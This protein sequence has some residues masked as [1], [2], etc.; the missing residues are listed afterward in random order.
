LTPGATFNGWNNISINGGSNNFQIMLEGQELTSAYQNQ[1]SDELQPSVEAIEQFTIQT[2]NFS[3]EY[4]L[5]GTGGLYNFTTKSG[6]NQPHGSAYEYFENTF[7]NAGIPFTGGDFSG[8]APQTKVVKHTDDYGGTFG[9]PVWIPKI[10]NGKNKTFFFFNLERYRDRELLFAGITTVPN[11]SFRAGDFSN[12]LLVTTPP[13]RVLGT[14]FA[15]QTLI[16]NTIYD[17]ATTTL[18]SAGQRILSP[19]P[20]NMIPAAR[21]NPVSVALLATLPQPN[22]GSANQFVNNYSQSGAFFKLQTLPSL[23]LD[24]NIGTKVKMSLYLAMENTNKS[25]GVDGLPP[26]ISQVRDQ[27]IRSKTARF[28]FDETLSPTLLFHFGA[29]FYRHY[30]PDQVTGAS[31]GYDL[32]AIGQPT[33]YLGYPR[34]SGIGDSTYGGMAPAFGPGTH[35]H[36]I[37]SKPTF[38]GSLSKVRGNHTIKG[39]IEWK[40]DQE[41]YDNFIYTS[42]AFAFSSSETSQPLYGQVLPSGTGLGSGFASFLLGLYDSGN[43]GNPSQPMYRRRSVALYINDTWKLTPKLTLDYGLRWDIQQPLME[44]HDREASF[45][46]SVPNENASGVLGGYIY[47]GFGP[48]RCNCNLVPS[49][50]Y[51]VAPRLGLAYQITP[52]TVLRAGWGIS[53]GQ[54]AFTASQPST[55]GMGF[56]VINFNAVGN[57]VG[58]GV[59]GQPLP[60]VTPTNLYQASYDPGNLFVPG[61]SIGGALASNVDSNGGRPPRVEQWNISLQRE[62]FKDLIVEVFLVGNRAAWLNEGTGMISYDAV[63]PAK[64]ASVGLGDLTNANTRTLLS[65]S[66][67][68]PAAVAAG[69]TLPYPTFPTTG[70]VLQSLRPYPQFSSIGALWAPLGDSWYDAGNVKVTKRLS[71]GLVATFTYAH[72]MAEDSTTNAGS[73]YNRASFKGLAATDVPNIWSFSI[74]Y[75]IP[76][77]AFID[78]HRILHGILSGWRLGTLDTDASGALL[79]TPGSSNSIGSYVSTGYTRMVRNPGIPLYLVNINCNCFDPTKTQVLNPAAWTNQAAGVPGSNVVYYNDFRGERRPVTSASLGKIFRFKERM[80]FSIRAEFFNVFNML[81]GLGNP[82]TSSPQNPL[83]YQNGLITSGFGSMSYTGFTSNSVNSTFPT[84]R[85]GQLV[86]RIDF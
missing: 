61:A 80:N 18:N 20:N 62:I 16:Q 66:I 7:L 41:I 72:S 25:N 81:E 12:N 30:N 82:S 71:H 84:P 52:K 19:F 39:G 69:F 17:P 75:T 64:L 44:T 49:Y 65:S 27:Y 45:G 83:T 9:G 56:N 10:Y 22:I 40:I 13:N 38:T 28:N 26:I 6:A 57:G 31:Y 54:L 67:T 47:D 60:N 1:V 68:S 2:S 55:T 35:L 8:G 46:F 85:T 33:P 63:S 53:Y 32:A 4:G 42:P 24:Q 70:T 59:L 50:P 11:A 15:G 79:G 48:G 37:D 3:A 86:A 58:A 76:T 23:K 34:I 77:P 21:F 36:S 29:G 14:S 74:D 73:I 51:A 78:S 43:I 5:I